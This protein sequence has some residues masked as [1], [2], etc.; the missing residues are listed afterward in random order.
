MPAG[1]RA[2]CWRCRNPLERTAGRSIQAALACS[3]SGLA[4][5]L[6]ANLMTLLTVQMPVGTR[7]SQL[8]DSIAWLWGHQ[9]VLLAMFTAYVVVIPLLRS[10]SGP[11]P[12]SLAARPVT[13]CPIGG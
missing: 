12:R 8:W 11:A 2:S 3:A 13:R 1:A 5:L 7:S 10:H 4:L 9:W 6:P